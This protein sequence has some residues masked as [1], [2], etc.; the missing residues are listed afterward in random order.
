MPAPLI[1]LQSNRN[2]FHQKYFYFSLVSTKQPS[3]VSCCNE[4]KTRTHIWVMCIAFGDMQENENVSEVYKCSCFLGVK[5]RTD[6]AFRYGCHGIHMGHWGT[7][8]KLLWWKRSYWSLFASA[9]F[10]LSL[11]VIW[12]TV[13]THELL[14]NTVACWQLCSNSVWPKAVP[15]SHTR[16]L[17]LCVAW[18]KWTPWLNE[19][20]GRQ[21]ACT[22]QQ[23]VFQSDRFYLDSRQGEPMYRMRWMKLQEQRIN[24]KEKV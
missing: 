4:K 22:G 1:L 15:N 13:H 6:L 21:E 10:H 16:Q 7:R 2:A 17:C 11:M 12:P 14:A 9:W 3:W 19:G 8:Q 23:D 18:V 20:G 24:V 5:V